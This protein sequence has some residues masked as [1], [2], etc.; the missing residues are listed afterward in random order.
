VD[1]LE[2]AFLLSAYAHGYFPMNIEGELCW[3]SPDPRAILP[4]DAVHVP[5]TLRQLM[6]QNRFEVRYD[7]CYAEIV[8]ACAD[9]PDGTWISPD[10]IAA[11]VR[12]HEFGYA[13]SIEVWAGDELAGGLYGVRLGAA[14]FGESMFHR[15]RDAS[16]VALVAL[17]ERMRAAGF[18]L[19]DVQYANQHLERF[20]VVQIPKT[21]YLARLS[22]ALKQ[23]CTL[24]PGPVADES[25]C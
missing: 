6:R 11:Y 5:R 7:T 14:F 21:E 3:L 10:I 22:D 18:T 15:R 13:H 23:S 17:V 2:P 20:G 1:P 8:R 16:K 9:R 19:L 4:L 25:G 24:V 12:L